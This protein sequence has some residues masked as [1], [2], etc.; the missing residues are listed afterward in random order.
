VADLLVQISNRDEA[1]ILTLIGPGDLLGA[2]ILD[3]NLLAISAQRQTR[4]VV[5]LG[6]LT[7][8]SS[9]FMG[10]LI[11]LRQSVGHAKGKIVMCAASETVL[12]AL[13]RARLDQVFEIHPAVDDAV[14]AVCVSVS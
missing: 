9:I 5:D 4:V 11:R 8:I 3:K 7:F 2:G 6:G 14:R 1:L 12:D 13:K 10:S